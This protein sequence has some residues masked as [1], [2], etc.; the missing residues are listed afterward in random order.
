MLTQ[1]TM[2]HVHVHIIWYMH[3][4]PLVHDYCFEYLFGSSERAWSIREGLSSQDSQ[5]RFQ[6]CNFLVYTT[7]NSIN[8]NGWNTTN[9]FC[10]FSYL[11]FNNCK[12]RTSCSLSY[13][14]SIINYVYK[15]WHFTCSMV[16]CMADNRTE[17][18]CSSF[19]SLSWLAVTY[20]N[21]NHNSS[22][23]RRQWMSWVS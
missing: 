23:E 11:T 18:T 7:S 3:T 1:D 5:L 13:K 15:A 8:H 2:V 14:Y 19:E 16:T 9:T 10:S 6:W 22:Y 17:L 4:A 20:Q 21:N 12:S